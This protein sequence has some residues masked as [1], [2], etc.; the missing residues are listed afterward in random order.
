MHIRSTREACM[1]ANDQ[2]YY[3]NVTLIFSVQPADDSVFLAS[4]L[5]SP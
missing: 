5:F 4:I 1:D 3:V 2:H